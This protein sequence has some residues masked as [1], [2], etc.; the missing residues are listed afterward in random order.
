MDDD[1]TVVSYL[2]DSFK[3]TSQYELKQEN[4]KL[5]ARLF[6]AEES[7][8]HLKEVIKTMQGGA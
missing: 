2:L 1:T 7:N 3:G 4:M 5:K 8:K 6:D